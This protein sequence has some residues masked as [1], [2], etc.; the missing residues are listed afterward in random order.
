MA[1]PFRSLEKQ[2]CLRVSGARQQL[3]AAKRPGRGRRILRDTPDVFLLECGY[4]LERNL[5][6]DDPLRK[7][8]ME[9]R[10][11]NCLKKG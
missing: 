10:G 6:R 9:R 5:K 11:W 2:Y 7:T 3:R 1:C 4:L 8:E